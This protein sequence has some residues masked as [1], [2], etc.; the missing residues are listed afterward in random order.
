MEEKIKIDKKVVSDVEGLSKE[1]FE[2]IGINVDLEVKHDEENDAVLLN[3]I[4]SDSTGLLIGRRGENLSSLQTI[5]GMMTKQKLGG[6]VRVILDVGD[7]RHKQESEL[8]E[9][10]SQTAERARESRA[11]QALYNL[12]PSQRRIIH[13]ALANEKDIDTESEGEGR[14]RHLVI[15]VKK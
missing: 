8:Q 13:L 2:L 5:L 14:D 12:S 1:L 15:S 9:L 11:P 6:W 4:S 7:W 3:L 10:A